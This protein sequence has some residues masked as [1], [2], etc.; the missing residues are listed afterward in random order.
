MPGAGSFVCALS[1]LFVLSFRLFVRTRCAQRG[2]GGPKRTTTADGPGAVLGEAR[3]LLPLARGQDKGA[4]RYNDDEEDEEQRPAG[5]TG[6]PH[7]RK[8]W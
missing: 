4:G 5:R 7:A 1:R 3:P 6:G 8:A 2:G